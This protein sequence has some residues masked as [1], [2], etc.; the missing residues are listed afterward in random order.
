MTRTLYDQLKDLPENSWNYQTRFKYYRKIPNPI[1][2]ISS[3]NKFFLSYFQETGKGPLYEYL[4]DQKF[5]PPDPKR[6]QHVISI[7]FLGILLYNKMPA[8]RKK[9]LYP[10]ITSTMYHFFPF[11]WSLICFTHDIMFSSE[12]NNPYFN[13]VNTLDDFLERLEI[14]HDLRRGIKDNKLNKVLRQR[15]SLCEQY[16]SY[17][18]TDNEHPGMDHGICAGFAVYHLLVKIR[19]S[20]ARNKRSTKFWKKFLEDQYAYA[21][22]TVAVHNM[23]KTNSTD[24]NKAEKYASSKLGYLIDTPQISFNDAP[25]LFFLGLVDTIDPVKAYA[26]TDTTFVLKNVFISFPKGENKLFTISVSDNLDFSV[27]KKKATEAKDWLRIDFT[28]NKRKR[29]VDFFLG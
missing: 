18:I 8:L 25:L 23:W 3:Y 2:N 27:M 22:A 15:F 16:F 6:Q 26:S 11:V 14:Q 20:K 17:R 4:Q 7:F 10:G 9:V 21:A 24:K 13:D 1:S 12:R 29:E 28:A 19:R 5:P